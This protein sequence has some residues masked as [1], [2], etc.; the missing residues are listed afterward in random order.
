MYLSTTEGLVLS[1][2]IVMMALLI[3]ASIYLYWRLD[4]LYETLMGRYIKLHESW[5]HQSR[6][7]RE[8][9]EYIM[10]FPD[11]YEG[12]VRSNEAAIKAAEITMYPEMQDDGEVIYLPD[13][14]IPT[15][16]HP[17]TR[18]LIAALNGA[19]IA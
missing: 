11:G 6:S 17:E 3:F 2:F 10:T 12:F 4:N 14:P 8:Y 7:V 16:E 19:R 13:T 18:E 15:L 9:R 1:G 5:L